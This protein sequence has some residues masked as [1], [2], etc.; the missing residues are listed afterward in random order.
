[1]ADHTEGTLLSR[2]GRTLFRASGFLEPHQWA[3]GTG[4]EVAPEASAALLLSLDAVLEP[5]APVFQYST[6]DNS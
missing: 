6:T 1:M 3:G 4:E 5:C 2:L